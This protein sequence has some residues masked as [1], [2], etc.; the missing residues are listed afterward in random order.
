MTKKDTRF[1]YG[2]HTGVEGLD[3]IFKVL[4]LICRIMICRLP[5]RDSIDRRR[6]N[7][8]NDE[9]NKLEKGDV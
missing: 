4:C 7:K 9:L 3:L 1:V 6:V 5:V 2:M 8:F